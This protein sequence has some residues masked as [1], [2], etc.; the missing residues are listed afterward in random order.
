LLLDE[1][2]GEVM[3]AFRKPVG[4][5]AGRRMALC[6]T[7]SVAAIE[8]PKLA[9]EL[10][11]H[12][13]DVT[14]YM[15]EAAVDYGVSPHVM[16][17]ATGKPVVLKL[18]GK[19]EHLE[20]YDLVLVYPATLNTI[21]KLARGLAD[22]A[23]TAL[24]ASTDPSRLLVAPAMNLKLYRNAFFVKNME[25]L[26]KVGVTFLEPRFEEG[27]AKVA[28]VEAAVDHAVR[29]L[30]TSKLKGRGVLI[31]TGPTR[32]DLDP[33]RYIS[34]K[35]TGKLGYWLSKEAFQRGCAVKVIY[36]PGSVVFPAYI[37]VVN[38]Y[39][40]EDM[41][42]EALNELEKGIYETAIFSAAI[43]DFKPA[44]CWERKIRS[45]EA[46]HV[47]F[48]PTVKVID[49]V[50]RR[51]P[52]LTIVGFKLE[53]RVSREELVGKA[54][55]ELMRVNA[56]LVVANDLSEVKGESHRACLVGKGGVVKDFEGS[57]AEL[58]KEIFDILEEKL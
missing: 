3:E 23:V 6:L 34:N 10:R 44:R 5:L 14:C 18:T 49:E 53:Y 40:V 55:E 39:T 7:G 47:K 8:A 22:N 4:K 43:L 37:P 2:A 27:V 19:A 51:H 36:G 9:R 1:K 12:G 57:K 28:S 50:S 45:E 17:W 30:S 21:S 48:E 35:S 31:L 56:S 16:E 20:D 58:A 46:I 38:V 52:S 41:L 11:R 24:C 25:A 26:R 54:Y 33:V 29:C 32:Y 13:A 42:K 15:T